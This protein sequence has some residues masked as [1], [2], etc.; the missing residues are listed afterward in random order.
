MV[1]PFLGEVRN[2][3]GDYAPRNWA[4]CNGQLMSIAQNTA[5]FSLLGTT[6]GG[7]GVTTFGLP[8]LQGTLAISQGN[9]PGLTPRTLGEVGGTEGVTLL[10]GNLPIHS[11]ALNATTQTAAVGAPSTSVLPGTIPSPGHLYITP[12]TPT[13]LQEVLPALACGIAGQSLPHDNM[14]P[15]LVITFII[16]LS[17]IF[18][19]RN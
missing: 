17:G 10:Q 7:N 1:T 4:M 16:A 11:H 19:T 6:F 13:P 15:A 18:P 8:N 3:G 12:G 5:L 2:F 9:G 14:M